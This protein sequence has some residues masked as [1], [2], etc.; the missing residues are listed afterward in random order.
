MDHR[1]QEYS[2]S[3]HHLQFRPV[4]SAH[5]FVHS[6]NIHSAI[7]QNKANTLDQ[8]LSFKNSQSNR[9]GVS[10]EYGSLG[11]ASQNEGWNSEARYT[12]VFS[13]EPLRH[14]DPHP[15]EP[16][17]HPQTFPEVRRQGC[18]TWGVVLDSGPAMGGSVLVLTLDLRLTREEPKNSRELT[19]CLFC[20]T[21]LPCSGSTH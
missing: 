4:S 14:P 2:D 10:E 16:R 11:D 15:P 20:S 5:S 17:L 3:Q 12:S 1:I 13:K 8:N 18:P 6:A 7:E 9:R 21:F 19:H